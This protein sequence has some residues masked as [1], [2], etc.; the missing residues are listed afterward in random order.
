V[1][2]GRFVSCKANQR[3]KESELLIRNYGLEGK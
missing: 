3:G 1:Q 2:A